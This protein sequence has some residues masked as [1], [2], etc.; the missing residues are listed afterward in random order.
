MNAQVHHSRNGDNGRI[1]VSGRFTVETLRPFRAAAKELLA[2]PG[3]RNLEIDLSSVSYLD[4]S[5]LGSMLLLRDQL[6]GTVTLVGASPTIRQI[7]EV[8]NFQKLF[9][10]R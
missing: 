9:Q 2:T 5:A 10:I 4:S 6:G 3:L 8:A 1:A 7:F